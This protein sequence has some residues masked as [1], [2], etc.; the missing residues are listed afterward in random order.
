FDTAE[1]VADAAL[2]AKIHYTDVSAEQGATA[3]IFEKFDGP[4]R[5]AGIVFLPAMAFFG[6]LSD[7][8]V[9]ALM[10]GWDAADRVETYIGFDRW[11]PT[12]GTRNTIEGK[13]VGNLIYVGGRLTPAPSQ[14]AQKTWIF[15]EPVGEQ[16]VLEV[17]FCETIL[18]S[19]H[20]KTAEHHNYLTQ[21]AIKDVLNPSTPGPK[22]ADEMGRSDQ[23]FV[24]DV[25]VTRGDERRRAITRGRD[26]YAVSAPLTGIAVDRLVRGEFITVG[27]RA[28][29]EVFIPEDL[30]K[31]LGPEH[32][33]FRM[34]TPA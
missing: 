7:L 23:N 22:P 14:P 29:G 18:L 15:E 31:A 11:H 24:V 12:Q 20:V 16:V 10:K 30:L 28:P 21:I 1:A 4:A 17:P 27:A 25:I 13:R 33:T 8:M 26:G 2:R 6:G 3:R 34:V 5:E 32:A 19:R 9:T